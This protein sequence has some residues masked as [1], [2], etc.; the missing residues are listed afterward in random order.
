MDISPDPMQLASTAFRLSG[1]PTI[2]VLQESQAPNLICKSAINPNPTEKMK[3]LRIMAH[4]IIVSAGYSLD[5][6][7]QKYET[8]P[9]I[10]PYS[11]TEP[12]YQISFFKT[13]LSP[14]S[15]IRDSLDFVQYHRY[16]LRTPMEVFKGD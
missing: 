9:S 11:L 7:L 3:R 14:G 10:S 16:L 8:S 4:T 2:A 13:V 6:I 15:N 12:S 5:F 1:P